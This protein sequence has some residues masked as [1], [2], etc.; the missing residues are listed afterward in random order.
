M[1]I[2]NIITQ[3]HYFYDNNWIETEENYDITKT[4]ISDNRFTKSLF[5]YTASYKSIKHLKK[6]LATLKI[7]L[8]TYY[9]LNG[10]YPPTQHLHYLIQSNILKKIPC[11]P[12]T[13]NNEI[14]YS[15]KGLTDWYY[16]NIN[17]T[18]TIFS[19]THPNEVLTWNY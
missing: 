14:L 5:I 6:S 9:S 8:K 19:Y 11:N 16:T 4:T 7:A 3:N 2:L 15:L 10:I 12:Y 1:K 17:N 18:I 13:N